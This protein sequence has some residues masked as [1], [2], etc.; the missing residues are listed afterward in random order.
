[1]IGFSAHKL[2]GLKGCGV[3]YKKKDIDLEPIVYGSQEQGLFGGTENI[4]GI[5]ALGKA[6]ENYDYST[7][8][9]LSRDYVYNRLRAEIP[10]CYLVGSLTNRLPHNLYMCFKGIQGNALML[11]LDE[12]DIQVSIGSACNSGNP[13]PSTTLSA[14]GFNKED[15]HSCIRMSFSGNETKE[16]LNYLCEVIKNKVNILRNL[17]D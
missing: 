10:D 4:L 14:I 3:L 8:S 1:M 7:I 6:V 9:I 11:L 13:M 12:N 15:V 2:G 17:M 16:E 5:A